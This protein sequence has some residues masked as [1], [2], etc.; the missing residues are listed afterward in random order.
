MLA[1]DELPSTKKKTPKELQNQ[2]HLKYALSTNRAGNIQKL[3]LS[4]AYGPTVQERFEL[5]LPY[6]HK[7]VFYS[8]L[9][10]HIC[11]VYLYY[12][13][14]ALIIYLPNW[15]GMVNVWTS[16]LFL[17]NPNKCRIT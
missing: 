4:K 16:Y 10:Q 7:E 9:Q 11:A 13:I 17:D 1:S 14:S 8:T 6:R 12:I 3:L 2:E 5:Y 15:R